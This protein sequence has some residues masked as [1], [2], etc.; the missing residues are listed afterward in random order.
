MTDTAIIRAFNAKL[1]SSP[2][3]L[4]LPPVPSVEML[5]AAAE[6]RDVYRVG[7]RLGDYL[8]AWNHEPDDTPPFIPAVLVEAYGKQRAFE[9]CVLADA[10]HGCVEGFEE[11][12]KRRGREGDTPFVLS[13]LRAIPISCPV[14]G[15]PEKREDSS[16]EHSDHAASVETENAA[17]MRY[18]WWDMDRAGAVHM[19]SRCVGIM[20]LRARQKESASMLFSTVEELVDGAK[21]PYVPSY[22]KDHYFDD[23]ERSSLL[24]SAMWHASATAFAT[25]ETH[26][27]MPSDC[28]GHAARLV[29]A[30]SK[31]TN[32]RECWRGFYTDA[33]YSRVEVRTSAG[34]FEATVTESGIDWEAETHDDGTLWRRKGADLR[35]RRE[36]DM[37]GEALEA[38]DRH[39]GTDFSCEAM[40]RCDD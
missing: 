6:R 4:A 37:L 22:S 24:I 1:G 15:W 5:V 11:W 13:W 8:V 27:P 28:Y 3:Y 10:W 17:P 16:K 35:R 12:R 29:D 30:L 34:R 32:Y 33:P 26:T 9:L 39:A 40:K 23:D 19:P 38:L 25:Q 20:A 7:D 14:D 36:A 2:G 31:R 21:L 18:G